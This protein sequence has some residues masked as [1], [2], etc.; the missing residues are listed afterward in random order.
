MTSLPERQKIIGLL[1]VAIATGAR[2][3]RACAL[4]CVSQSTV[5]RWRRD[6]GEGDQR[7]MRLQTPCNRLSMLERQRLLAVANSAEFGHLPASQIVPR[8]ADRGQYLA[9]ESSF[10]RV[11]KAANQLRHRSATRPAQA[12]NKPR[13]VVATAPG[14]LF[15]WDIT[16]LP[17]RIRGVH[18]YLYLFI[19]IFSRKIVGWQVYENESSELAA[20]LMR[21]ICL[22]ERIAPNQVVLHSDNGAPMRGSSMLAALQALGVIPSFSRP[23]VSNDNPFS[24]AL[25]KTLKYCPLYPRRPF[26]GLAE[27]R[28]W[29]QTFA[30]WYNHEHRHSAIGFVTPEQ[31]HTGADIVLL[32]RREEVYET[33]KARHP[34]RW[35]GATRNWKPIRLVHLNPDKQ[36][37]ENRMQPQGGSSVRNAA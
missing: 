1:G 33:A 15:S 23:A 27:A 17:T 21:D 9:S 32:A 31:R 7:P 12:R 24:E 35:S 16:Y 13:A 2:Q 28:R 30:Q 19:D 25:F 6:T 22:R 18:L 26:T 34:K 11:L 10:H 8:L 20:E 4:I 29:V 5:R 37:Q 36:V 3:D 14:Q